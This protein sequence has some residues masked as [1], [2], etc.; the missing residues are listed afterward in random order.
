MLIERQRV[1]DTYVK[2]VITEELNSRIALIQEEVLSRTRLQPII[3]RLHLF[4]EEAPDATMDELI[5]KMQKAIA[6]TPVKPIARTRDEAF[7]GFSID[8]TLD[9]P[10]KAQQVCAEIASMFVEENIRQREGSA[11]GTASFLQSQLEDAKRKLDEQDG[12]LAAFKRQHMGSLPDEMQTNLNLLSALNTQLEAVTQAVNRAQQDKAYAESVLAQQIQAWETTKAMKSGSNPGLDSA[13]LEK[14]LA[15]LQILLANLETTYTSGHPDVVRIKA[16]IEDLKKKIQDTAAP[17]KDKLSD[18]AETAKIPEP[19]PSVAAQ[20]EIEDP[21]E[22]VHDAG[23]L[24]TQEPADSTEKA[25]AANIPEPPQIQQLRAQAHAYEQA[26]ETGIAEQQRVRDQIKQYQSRLQLSPGVEQEYKEITRDH[27][28]ALLFYNDLL[29]K[30]DQ[31]AMAT[32]MEH[33]QEGERFRVLDPANLPE[34]PSFPNKRLFALGGLG[35]GLALGLALTGIVEGQNKSLRTEHDIEFYLGATPFGLIPLIERTENGQHDGKEEFRSLRSSLS[36]VR[37]RQTLQRLLVTSPLPGE[38]K[39]LVSAFLAGAILWQHERRVLLIDADLRSSRLHR[40]LGAPAAPGL[41]DYLSGAADESSII[42]RGPVD[43]LSFI[44]GG[45]PAE[46]ASEL[47][48]NGRLKVLLE[49]MAS[50]FDWIIIDSPPVIPISDAKLIAELC[51]GVLVV[52][53]AGSTPFDLAQR[54]YGQFR[55]KRFLGVVLNQVDPT[56]TYGYNRYRYYGKEDNTN[57]GNSGKR[58]TKGAP[59]SIFK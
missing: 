25:K 33:R 29:S 19:S 53:R 27:E 11:Q 24:P 56:S 35:I 47:L 17:S 5:V 31:S 2:P 18:A 59:M 46:N 45:K 3:E 52:V 12:R 43:N 58:A 39:T 34:K 51:D 28:T 37:E 9:D 38:G 54:A 8:V 36:L 23:A 10:P 32:N 41:S 30:R 57:S 4:K 44:P 6:L 15:D 55:D 48:A 20:G 26:V 42:W 49:R 1:P 21:K 16:E 50:A 40:A 7:P 13:P 22:K 14:R